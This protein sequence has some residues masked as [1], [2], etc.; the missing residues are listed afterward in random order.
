MRSG[1]PTA[2]SSSPCWGR[3]GF[4]GPRPSPRPD[5]RGRWRQDI[6]RG[7]RAH[8]GERHI[9]TLIP[10]KRDQ[11]VNRK[12][13]GGRGGRTVGRDGDP[14]KDRNTVERLID[15]IKAWRGLATR[16]DKTPESYLAGLHLRASMI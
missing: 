14:Y 1:P 13:K 8:L 3:S 5:R 15:R 4:A 6:P 12:K 11:A 9:K 7:N 2:R 16:F 10:Q